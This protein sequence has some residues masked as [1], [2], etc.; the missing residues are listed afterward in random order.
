M[1]STYEI[2]VIGDVGVGKTTFVSKFHHK[3]LNIDNHK[4]KTIVS[5][6]NRPK[7]RRLAD[8]MDGI[9]ILY[10][11]ENPHSFEKAIKWLNK[12]EKKA[13]NILQ[14]MLVANKQDL[15]QIIP[16]SDGEKI[17][18]NYKIL[19][20]KVSCINVCDLSNVFEILIR[21]IH[22]SYKKPQPRRFCTLL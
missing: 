12:I 2:A 18:N 19:F 14:I 20:S 16:N 1:E 11:V 21:K 4:I 9:I 8:E 22:H 10:D 17:S 15:K 3:Y 6:I 5:D 13:T 7:L